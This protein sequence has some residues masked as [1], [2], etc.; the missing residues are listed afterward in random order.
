M[1]KNAISHMGAAMLACTLS[2]LPCLQTP[3]QACAIDAQTQEYAEIITCA[4]N[5]V[6]AEYGLSELTLVPI[7]IEGCEIRAEELPTQFSHYRPDGST[8]FTA[9]KELGVTYNVVAENIAG[10]RSDPLGT[11]NQWMD[12]EGHRANILGESYT[13]IGIG[14]HYEADSTYGHYWSMFLIGKYNGSEPYVYDDQYLPERV[15]GDVNGSKAIN[16][17][18]ATLILQ[19]AADSGAGLDTY[20]VNDFKTAADVN[21]DGN[22]NSVD[23]SVILT[24]AAAC[25]AG[26]DAELK[27][28]CW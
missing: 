14:Y 26:I 18:D 13:H 21:G 8:C 7:L 16:A 3:Q 15:T 27:D 17:S 6:R 11:F 23:A 22:I 19:F 1:K 5:D 25:G 10:G 28:F 20:A 2:L 4:V 12:S 9:I 24:Y